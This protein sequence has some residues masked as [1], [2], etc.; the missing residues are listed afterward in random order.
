MSSLKIEEEKTKKQTTNNK[1]Q[2]NQ[3]KT[4]KR[5][6]IA[7]TTVE[8]CNTGEISQIIHE[9]DSLP[10]I[11]F[12]HILQTMLQYEYGTYSLRHK[13]CGVRGYIHELFV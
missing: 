9:F 7:I 8:G 11:A 2:T 1:Q 3:Q 13:K 12:L 5:T 10:S 4:R 6:K